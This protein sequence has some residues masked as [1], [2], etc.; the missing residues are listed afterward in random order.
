MIIQLL[1][2]G[3]ANEVVDM[4]SWSG[5]QISRGQN[6]DDRVE[7]KQHFFGL[8]RRLSY[9]TLSMFPIMWKINLQALIINQCDRLKLNSNLL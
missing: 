4:S 2:F 9:I 7:R 5:T 3:S 6:F 8:V 1:L